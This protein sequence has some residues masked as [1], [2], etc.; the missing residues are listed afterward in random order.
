MVSI[1]MDVIQF[2]VAWWFKHHGVGSNDPITVLIQNISQFCRDKVK[3]KKHNY[4]VWLPP[5]NG[6]I[7]FNVDGSAKGQP[8]PAGIGG[9][10]RNSGGMMICF[11]SKD[12][13]LMI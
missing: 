2:R 6:L 8:G 7:K 13:Q 12:I 4:E 5:G 1:A 10:L 9:V 3:L 11:F